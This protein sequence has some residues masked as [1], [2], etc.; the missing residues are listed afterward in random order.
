MILIVVKRCYLFLVLFGPS[1]IAYLSNE[2]ARFVV[3]V[4]LTAI[5]LT[6]WYVGD[7]AVK[8]KYSQVRD[9]T[10]DEMVNVVLSSRRSG[11][12]D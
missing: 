8:V 4:G 12:T 10:A 11:S 7:R 1:C 5:L 6:L 2:L 3:A 9:E